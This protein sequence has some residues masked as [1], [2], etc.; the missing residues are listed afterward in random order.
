[1]GGLAESPLRGVSL[2]ADEEGVTSNVV[3]R[4]A[5]NL[6]AGGRKRNSGSPT[7]LGFPHQGLNSTLIIYKF[8]YLRVRRDIVRLRER[9]LEHQA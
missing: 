6:Q 1:M 4:R 8:Y 3:D 5:G 2:G 7:R 9:S